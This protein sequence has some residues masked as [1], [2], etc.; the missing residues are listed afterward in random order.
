M[1]M[2]WE[3]KNPMRFQTQERE[4]MQTTDDIK[5]GIKNKER[6]MF[7]VAKVKKGRR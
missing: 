6:D 3:K 5:D 2:Y 7:E 1:H 4:I